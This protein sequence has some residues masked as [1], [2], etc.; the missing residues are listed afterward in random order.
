[1]NVLLDTHALL[2]SIGRS[3]EL[4]E[5]VTTILEDG[6]NEVFVSAVSLWE[7]ELKCRVG[8]LVLDPLDISD[9][10]PVCGRLGFTLLP[11]DAA[12]V[13]AAARLNRNRIHKDPFDRMLIAQCIRHRFTF[14]SRDTRL[15]HY[16][17]DGLTWLW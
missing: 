8:K 5:C 6:A 13:L 15:A 7:I 3:S 17:P 11:L 16:K 10:P 12:D 4:S 14:L 1:M 2:W 9:I